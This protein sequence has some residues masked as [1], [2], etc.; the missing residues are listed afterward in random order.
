[1]MRVTNNNNGSKKFV[2]KVPLI[3]DHR[4]YIVSMTR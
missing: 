3:N 2:F 1:M 4:N